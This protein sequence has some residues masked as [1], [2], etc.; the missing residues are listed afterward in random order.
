MTQQKNTQP[1]RLSLL[2]VLLRKEGFCFG[3][4]EQC[5]HWAGGGGKPSRDQAESPASDPMHPEDPAP[6]Q[7]PLEGACGTVAGS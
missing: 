4:G 2:P 5:F 6:L 3:G 7:K 1:T